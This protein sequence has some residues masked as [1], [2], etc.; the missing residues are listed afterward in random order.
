MATITLKGNEIHTNG[1]L[2]AVGS[3]AADFKLVDAELGDKRLADYAGQAEYRAQ[4]GYAGVCDV[5]E[6]VQ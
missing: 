5:D 2:P 6:K 3:Q 1:E 4:S